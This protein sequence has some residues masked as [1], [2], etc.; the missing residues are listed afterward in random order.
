MAFCTV[1]MIQLACFSSLIQ[2]MVTSLLVS[3]INRSSY[4]MHRERELILALGARDLMPTLV[5]IYSSTFILAQHTQLPCLSWL[6]IV[7]NPVLEV[8]GLSPESGR[9]LHRM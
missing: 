8:F 6:H 9:A 5:D 4:C 7:F 2:L 3:P 1:S